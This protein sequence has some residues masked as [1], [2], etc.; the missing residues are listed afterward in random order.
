LPKGQKLPFWAA[1]Q[2][3]FAALD[4]LMAAHFDLQTQAANQKRKVIDHNWPITLRLNKT[5]TAWNR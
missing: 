5:K 3:C 4:T 1:K 2:D